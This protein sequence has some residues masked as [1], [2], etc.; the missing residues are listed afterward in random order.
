MFVCTSPHINTYEK[1]ERALKYENNVNAH[2]SMLYF[3]SPTALALLPPSDRFTTGVVRYCT[4]VEAS[5]H[6]PSL[7]ATKHGTALRSTSFRAM[8]L[9]SN[10]ALGHSWRHITHHSEIPK[11]CTIQYNT[12]QY[13]FSPFLCFPIRTSMLH[14]VSRNT[15]YETAITTVSRPIESIFVDLQYICLAPVL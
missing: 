6:T 1:I 9:Y 4:T 10:A 15:K 14:D 12:I 7:I 8:S 13:P 3:I 11:F 5:P 2:V